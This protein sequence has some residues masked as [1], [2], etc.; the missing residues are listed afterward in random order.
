MSAM[1]LAILFV[2]SVFISN[3]G[4]LDC[5][6][7]RNI[8]SLSECDRITTCGSGEVCHVEQYISESGLVL[9]NTGCLSNLQCQPSTKGGQPLQNTFRSGHNVTICTECCNLSFC[10][11]AGCG[12]TSLSMTERGPYCF[13]CDGIESPDECRRVKRCQV[14]EHCMLYSKPHIQG[15]PSPPSYTGLCDTESACQALRDV[16]VH[17]ECP[18]FCCPDD[19]CN[20]RCVGNTTTTT[21]YTTTVNTD[22]TGCPQDHIFDSVS[23]AC[24]QLV[25]TSNF[26]F[27][28]AKAFCNS[29][30]DQLVIIDSNEK[31]VFV[32]YV[33]LHQTKEQLSAQNY[34]IGAHAINATSGKQYHWLNGQTLAFERWGTGEPDHSSYQ[35]CVLIN[36]LDNYLWYDTFCH[37]Q[38]HTICE[39]PLT[40]HTTTATSNAATTPKS[41]S[42]KTTSTSTSS[43]TTTTT[44][45][46]TTT[47]TTPTTT[48]TTNSPHTTTK[49]QEHCPVHHH[50]HHDGYSLFEDGNTRLCVLIVDHRETWEDAKRNCA[51][52]HHH[53][54][55]VVLDSHEKMSLMDHNKEDH[56][57]WVGAAD[58]NSNNQFSWLNEHHV[59]PHLWNSGQP[60]D[61]HHQHCVAYVDKLLSDRN[62]DDEYRYICEIPL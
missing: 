28:E 34:W 20:D 24:I 50:N 39:R 43:S 18:A 36:G 29:I 51:N 35:R 32:T 30:G 2:A 42:V 49:A 40:Q 9:Y 14:D 23:S 17:T 1:L 58:Q 48:T 60:N 10:N 15:I 26:T 57:Y 4:C 59:G 56:D 61:P 13:T 3:G 44:T 5:F 47:K 16:N 62:C 8:L 53:G 38:Y 33:I 55:L 37:G 21:S 6:D 19:F 11:D 12:Q 22:Q 7:C 31:S 41:T 54:R 52:E 45:T 25:E 46:A 27:D